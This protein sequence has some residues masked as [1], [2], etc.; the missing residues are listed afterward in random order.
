VVAKTAGAS[1]NSI[2]VAATSSGTL[3]VAWGWEGYTWGGTPITALFGGSDVALTGVATANDG[4]EQGDHGIW[5]IVISA[6]EVNDAGVAAELAAAYLADRILTPKTVRY[7]TYA[8][9]LRPSQ[10][11]TVT[12]ADRDIDATC[13]ITDVAHRHLKG[14]LVLRSATA[15]SSALI[16]SVARWRSTYRMWGKT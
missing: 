12:V 5:E 10:T 6:P 4:G 7:D 11:Q 2:A 3:Q 1:G 14:T 9:G 8:Y 16:G 13:L 15:I